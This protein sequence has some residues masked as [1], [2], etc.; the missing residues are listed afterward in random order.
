MTNKGYIYIYI[1]IYIYA[2]CV[3]KEHACKYD[4]RHIYECGA[5][6]CMIIYEEEKILRTYKG[7]YCVIPESSD[8]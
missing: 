3:H 5:S 7:T 8:S 6:A 4:I 2:C 1:Y